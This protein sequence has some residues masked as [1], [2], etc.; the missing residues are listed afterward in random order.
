MSSL[1]ETALGRFQ[2]MKM[3]SLFIRPFKHEWQVPKAIQPEVPFNDSEGTLKLLRNREYVGSNP[4]MGA[5][6]D[7]TYE[8]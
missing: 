6:Q 5:I 8:R 3:A 1:L 4:T 7:S 2:R